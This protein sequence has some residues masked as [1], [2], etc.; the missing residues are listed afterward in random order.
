VI[1]PYTLLFTTSG[2]E[3]SPPY[4]LSREFFNEAIQVISNLVAIDP[5]I[6]SL[7]NFHGLMVI[8]DT[9]VSYDTWAAAITDTDDDSE[10]YRAIRISTPIF[11]NIKDEDV[12][13]STVQFLHASLKVSPYSRAGRSWLKKAR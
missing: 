11:S 9:Y 7:N 2:V 10:L 8:N 4:A 5:N 3:P 13:T 6:A 12:T 1:Y